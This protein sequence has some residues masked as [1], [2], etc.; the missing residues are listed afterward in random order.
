MSKRLMKTIVLIVFVVFFGM[1]NVHAGAEIKCTYEGGGKNIKIVINSSGSGA[2]RK[3]GFD[4]KVMNW[5][6][7]PS[8]IKMD[9]TG[10][11]YYSSHNNRACPPNLYVANYCMGENE[12][13]FYG[14]GPNGETASDNYKKVRDG[15]D[16]RVG[17]DNFTCHPDFYNMK[18]KDEEINAEEEPTPDEPEP[19]PDRGPECT[20][21]ED[22]EPW[23][24][25]PNVNIIVKPFSN[26]FS[27]VS[28]GEGFITGIPKQIPNI[29]RMIY[30]FI[31]VIIPVSLIILGLLDMVKALAAQKEDEIKK[32]QH[33]FIKRLITAIIVFFVFAIVKFVFSIICQN[34]TTAID[35]V[36]CFIKNS[37][38]CV[39]E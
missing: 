11:S 7:N 16:D 4:A 39:E 30:S 22:D 20:G 18:L 9:F 19:E 29:T 6:K 23:C 34:S 28:C 31:Q 38:S 36:D 2:T 13:Y 12:A 3:S 17:W 1:K 8:E 15:V 37:S 35:C 24:V 5:R 10:S 21:S 33:M 26:E 25:D 14:P 27:T 32:G